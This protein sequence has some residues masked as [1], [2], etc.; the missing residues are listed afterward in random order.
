MAILDLLEESSPP[1]QNIVRSQL[2]AAHEELVGDP[3]IREQVKGRAIRYCYPLLGSP[4]RN[5]EFGSD[6]YEDL[7]TIFDE[8]IDLW[9]PL[10]ASV[11]RFVSSADLDGSWI[12]NKD[13]DI[14][15]R[16]DNGGKSS[17]GGTDRPMLRLFPRVEAG[18]QIIFA[19]VALSASQRAVIAARIEGDQTEAERHQGARSVANSSVR[20]GRRRS[21]S[22]APPNSPPSTSGTTIS[23]S[24]RDGQR[25]AHG[26]GMGIHLQKAPGRPDTMRD[27][28]R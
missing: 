16:S 27:Q 18:E 4:P 5:P 24:S 2:L 23:S 21:Y 1:R 11:N 19:G 25:R 7:R 22:A 6:F 20:G 17:I 10:Q 15:P 8:A 14:G 9:H 26:P 13:F 3:H 12:C 28:P